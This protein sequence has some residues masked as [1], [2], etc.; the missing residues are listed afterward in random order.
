MHIAATSAKFTA[1][2]GLTTVFVATMDDVIYSNFRKNVIMPFQMVL[3]RAPSGKVDQEDIK[4]VI[5]GTS[6]F[7]NDMRP[8]A[9][10]PAS[11]KELM[12]KDVDYSTPQDHY[13][14]YTQRRRNQLDGGVRM[15]EL[16]TLMKGEELAIIE[17]LYGDQKGRAH[18]IEHHIGRL[19]E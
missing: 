14:A 19:E 8:H 2:L 12:M 10:L 9:I 16:K 6:S 18:A 15:A 1:G 7:V 13:F 3:V 5:S 4:D 11:A 17:E